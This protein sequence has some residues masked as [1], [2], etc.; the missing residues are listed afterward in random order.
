M[1]V[2]GSGA[3]GDLRAPA[4]EQQVDQRGPGPFVTWV[5]YER[6]DGVVAR[7]GVA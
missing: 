4:A 1:A 5:M 2:S 7:L 6:P 3:A